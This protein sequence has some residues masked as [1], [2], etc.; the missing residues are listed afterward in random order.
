M[1]WSVGSGGM[2]MGEG[3]WSGGEGYC[4]EGYWVFIGGMARQRVMMVVRGM[5][6]MW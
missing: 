1:V 2:D 3:Y 6:W 4:D 5:V